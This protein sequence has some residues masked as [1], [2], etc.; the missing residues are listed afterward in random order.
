[1]RLAPVALALLAGCTA[2]HLQPLTAPDV[3]SILQSPDRADLVRRAGVLN[4]PAL[5][6]VVLDFSRPLTGDEVAVI[7]VIANPEL[8]S[9]RAQQDVADAQAFASGLLPDPQLG[10]GFDFLLSSA[11]P[12][13]ST[14]YAAS[15]SLDLL[16]ALVTRGVERQAAVA[17]AEQVRLDIAWQEW[18]SAG[19]ARLLAGRWFYQQQAAALATTAADAAERAQDRA[20]AAARD[21]DL[22]GSEIEAS[23]IVAS[24]ARSRALAATRDAVATRL[25]L[26]RILGLRPEE[27]VSLKEPGGL[28]HWSRPDVEQLFAMARSRR[29]DLRALE[30]GYASQEAVVHRAVLGQYP[31]LGITVNRARDTSA[32]N[33]LGPAVTFDLPLWNRNRGAIAVADADRN[34]LRAEYGARLHA[35]RS[36][37]AELVAAL[38]LDE[39]AREDLARQVPELER[40]AGAYEQAAARGDVTRPLADSSRASALDKRLALVALQQSCAE[41]RLALAVAVGLPLADFTLNTP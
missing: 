26:N 12:T 4:H 31:R 13:L 15:L 38:D 33:T 8:R 39:A 22:Q 2:Y 23:R 37:I 21:H 10:V 36:D 14:G 17:A 35:T 18:A 32:V 28:S 29:L 24:E 6:P 5:P 3:D 25:Q 34:R 40:I 27:M 11:D 41:Q 19:Q 16:A 9:L 30:Q 20:F 7:A 1:M